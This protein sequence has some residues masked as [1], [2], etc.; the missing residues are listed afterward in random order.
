[1]Q[2]QKRKPGRQSDLP[3]EDIKQ[4]LDNGGMRQIDV[5]T[6]YDVSQGTISRIARL[7]EK[8]KAESHGSA[9]ICT[10]CGERRIAKGNR[11]LCSV[12]FRS[13]SVEDHTVW[14]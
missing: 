11:F 4:M 1:M 5:A 3:V 7:P 12:C 14:A 10:C 2:P 9:H 6:I 8:S 13:E